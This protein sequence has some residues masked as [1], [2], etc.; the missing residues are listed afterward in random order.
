MVFDGLD[1]VATGALGSVMAAIEE[2]AELDFVRLLITAR[3]DT[4]LPKPASIYPLPRTADEDVI[5]Y[6]E[7]R[8]IP[9]ARREEVEEQPKATGSSHACSPTCSASKGMSK[10]ARRV[11]SL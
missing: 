7:R 4:A 2:L 10:S 9:D 5:Q 3:P 11:S 1:R 6:L 8:G